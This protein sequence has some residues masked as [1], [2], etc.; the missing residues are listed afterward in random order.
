MMNFDTSERNLC[1]VKRQST[2]TPLQALVLMNDPQ[3][4]EASRILAER[5][6]REGGGVDQTRIRYGFRLLTSREPTREEMHVLEDLLVK[7][8]ESFAHDREAARDL[9]ASG[10]YPRNERLSPSEVAAF[11][12]VASTIMNFDATT[13][14]R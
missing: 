3:F 4:V 13:I 11:T 8:R 1:T 14:L 7:Q 12:T 10:E 5:M 2:S 6:I 9:L